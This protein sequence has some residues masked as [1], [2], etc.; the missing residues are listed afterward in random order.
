MAPQV[1]GRPD[2]NLGRLV[3]RLQATQWA[4]LRTKMEERPEGGA[5]PLTRP[6]FSA[7]SGHSQGQL[8]SPTSLRCDTGPCL[9]GTKP[10]WARIWPQK[11]LTVTG[12]VSHRLQAHS[13]HL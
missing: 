9:A 7:R 6:P 2:S 1:S 12:Q 4:L 13:S 11:L 10:R 5:L 3:W 8:S